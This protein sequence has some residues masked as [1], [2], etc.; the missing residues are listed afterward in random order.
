MLKYGVLEKEKE[1]KQKIEKEF[2][3]FFDPDDVFKSIV[4]ISKVYDRHIGF[5]NTYRLMTISMVEFPIFHRLGIIVLGLDEVYLCVRTFFKEIKFKKDIEYL[6]YELLK[7]YKEKIVSSMPKDYI[8]PL[9]TL[10]DRDMD[11]EEFVSLFGQG[12]YDKMEQDHLVKITYGIRVRLDIF[13][14][15][16]TKIMFEV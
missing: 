9:K 14:K 12:L 8:E 6:D 15:I 10:A 2:E 3:K 4:D 5:P 16:L 7:P 1:L 13:G 11:Y